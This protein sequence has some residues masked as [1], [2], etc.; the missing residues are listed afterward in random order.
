MDRSSAIVTERRV[1]N[2]TWAWLDDQIDPRIDQES[3]ETNPRNKTREQ[4]EQGVS[5]V[6]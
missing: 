2:A 3:Q 6:G 4:A 5:V 1:S